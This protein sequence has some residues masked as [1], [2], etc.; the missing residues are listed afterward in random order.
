VKPW[1]VILISV[2][3][4]LQPARAA[5]RVASYI[6]YCASCNI[7]GADTFTSESG[8]FIVH[9]RS[10]GRIVPRAANANNPA[11]I[12][13][14]PQLVAVS[15][16]R[17]KRSVLEELQIQDQYRAKVHM[18]LLDLAPPDRPV[19]LLSKVYRDSVQYEIILPSEIDNQRF[20]RA[21][22]KVVLLEYANRGANHASEVPGWLVE[23]LTRQIESRIN[24][25]YVFNKRP[26]TI[27]LLGYDRLR[28]SREML[29]TNAPMTIQELSFGEYTSQSDLDRFNASAHL[30]VFELV[31][32][33]NGPAL[34][35]SFIRAL[36]NSHNWQTAFHA[37]YRNHFRT[38]LDLEKWWMLNWLD[39]RNREHK[40]TWSQPVSMERFDALLLTPM[41]LRLRSSDIPKKADAT[42]QEVLYSTD[43]G[44][45]KEIINQKIQ[46][47]FFVSMNLDREVLSLAG[48][49]EA[50]LKSYVHKRAANDVQ[51]GL[52]S[53][54]EQ[55]LQGIIRSTI[56]GLDDLDKK[57]AALRESSKAKLAAAKVP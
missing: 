44:V 50:L 43:F 1:V 55:R 12:Q 19:E 40:E 25:T 6:A 4:A 56:K 5:G 9:G 27:E 39:V 46:Q 49:Y 10:D 11:L 22:V 15:A 14:K 3:A 13:L 20:V 23:G 47:I 21:L 38:P 30:L 48:Q 37:V 28:G 29:R 45:Q 16:E 33:K 8:Q 41:E 31:R 35:A 52:K 54:P 17:V 24:P 2:L 18:V 53:D 32:M 42:L 51:P 36:P 26:K 34:L 7:W 57:R